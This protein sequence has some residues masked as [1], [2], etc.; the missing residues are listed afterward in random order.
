M[1]ITI[2]K[3]Y[4]TDKDKEG[5]PLMTKGSTDRPS[6]PYT[7]LAIKTKEHGDKWLSGFENR[8]T[9]NW[10]EGDIVDIEITPNGQYLN[11]KTLSQEDKMWKEINRQAGEI[12]NLKKQMADILR[13]F[14]Q[15][16][17]EEVGKVNEELDEASELE[18]SLPF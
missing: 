18:K 15:V 12:H 10:K 2:T 6:R 16:P 11:F 13:N 14:G 8:E 4:R 1:E 17:D 9:A 3:T 5:K 7:R